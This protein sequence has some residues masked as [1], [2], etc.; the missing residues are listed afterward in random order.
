[1][2]EADSWTRMSH[3]GL[4]CVLGIEDFV[5]VGER[6]LV[7]GERRTRQLQREAEAG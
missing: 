1:M 5:V 7:C 2:G 3:S 6:K 4:S